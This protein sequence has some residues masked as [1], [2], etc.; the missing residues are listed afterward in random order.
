[1]SSFF[2]VPLDTTEAANARLQQR[3]AQQ[4]ALYRNAGPSS[5]SA[6][7]NTAFA[8]IGAG[9]GG[10]PALAR[11]QQNAE[12]SQRVMGQITQEISQKVQEGADPLE[13]QRD[14]F[15]KAAT[16]LRSV[17]PNAS[18]E[19]MQKYVEFDQVLKEQ[20]ASRRKLKA[21]QGA[22][23]AKF[24]QDQQELEGRMRDSI[25]GVDTLIGRYNRVLESPN[26]SETA[27]A[28][29]TEEIVQLKQRRAELREQEAMRY[30]QRS[31]GATGLTVPRRMLTER[32]VG[33]IEYSYGIGDLADFAVS[34]PQA[35]G[36]GNRMVAGLSNLGSH[37]RSFVTALGD[38]EDKQRSYE[39]ETAA[40]KRLRDAARYDAQKRS[41][42]LDLAWAL[43]GSRESGRLSDTDIDRSEQILGGDT[44]DPRA[45]VA[46]LIGLNNRKM[47]SW[48]HM[49]PALGLEGDQRSVRSWEEA[50]RQFEALDAKLQQAA[51]FYQLDAASAEQFLRTGELPSLEDIVGSRSAQQQWRIASPDEQIPGP[52]MSPEEEDAF[53]N[54]FL[55]PEQ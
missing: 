33:N 24:Q 20:Q 8:Q 40:A 6:T 26:A 53:L 54:Q 27:K 36:F 11:Q 55:N 14:G 12:Q 4:G 23:A 35:F 52:T 13:A 25:G 21:E 50:Q 42:I 34:Q 3:L 16:E 44:P 10:A 1:M 37:Y 5:G 22:K 45:L 9:L 32:S 29:A 48:Q 7:I 18:R 31:S 30:A 39:I 15:L 46:T 43:A 41:A 38:S 49:L 17:N 2:G 47:R 51:E 19:M 28:K